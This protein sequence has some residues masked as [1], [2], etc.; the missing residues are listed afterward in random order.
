MQ[1][2][3]SIRVVRAWSNLLDSPYETP[4]CERHG[5]VTSPRCAC[6]QPRIGGAIVINP[7][8]P[9]P[10]TSAQAVGQ[11]PIGIL[12]LVGAIHVD[13]IKLPVIGGKEGVAGSFVKSDSVYR[14]AVRYVEQTVP[15]GDGQ[16][17]GSRIC[18]K[19]RV[20]RINSFRKML[21]RI[22][23]KNCLIGTY[24]QNP[25]IIVRLERTIGEGTLEF[26]AVKITKG[27]K[28]AF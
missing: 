12:W 15:F 22:T 8:Y 28:F 20:Y 19:K 6:L 13:K 3:Q 27:V 14:L 24:L 7:D 11:I 16:D 2:G 1:N 26:G 9:T 4:E 21:G 23:G 10:G 5:R 25:L 17:P 18:C